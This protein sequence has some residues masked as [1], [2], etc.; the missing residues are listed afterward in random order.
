ME[1]IGKPNLSRAVVQSVLDTIKNGNFEA[2]DR[3]PP[4]KEMCDELQVGI[5]SVREGLKQLQSMGIIKIVQGKGTYVNDNLDLNYFLKSFKDLI[6]LQRQDFFNVMEARKIIECEAARL[7]AERADKEKIHKLSELIED[8]GDSLKDMDRY[9][10]LDVDFHLTIVRSSKNPL[11]ET[12]LES[13]QGLISSI[14]KE[15]A[16]LPEQTKVSTIHHENIFSAIKNGKTN[17]AF[18]YMKEHLIEVEEIAV[19]YLYNET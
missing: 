10:S 9:N 5:S 7:A 8:M 13:I 16:V 12:F 11:L 1:P 17:L 15:I 18:E 14:V 2:G 6:T 3:L 19:K 4:M